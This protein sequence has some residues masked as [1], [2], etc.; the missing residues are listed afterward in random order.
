MQASTIDDRL[1]P[2]RRPMIQAAA[3]NTDA[4][5]ELHKRA[6]LLLR[7]HAG[8]LHRVAVS[9]A[10]SATE[11]DDLLQEIAL[12]LWTALPNFRGECS[13]RSFFVSHRAQPRTLVSGA[14][15]RDS[16]GH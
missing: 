11:R 3:R 10:R 12:A 7:A 8:I 16:R 6:V 13:E 9:Y 2:D 15:G 4:N 5:A 14:Q 1:I